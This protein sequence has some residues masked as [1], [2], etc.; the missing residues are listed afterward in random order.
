MNQKNGAKYQSSP[1]ERGS[2]GLD[3]GRPNLRRVVPARAGVIRIIG[4]NA[5]GGKRRP[6]ASGGHP[7]PCSP[8]GTSVVSS[9][10]E[11][12]SSAIFAGCTSH[13]QVVPARAGV[14][15]LVSLCPRRR[16]GR[17]RASG[18]HPFTPVAGQRRPLS[19]PR[20]RGS[21]DDAVDGRAP[22]S[23]VPARAGVIRCVSPSPAGGA[24][25]PRASGGHPAST[26][27]SHCSSPSSPRERGSSRLSRPRGCRSESSPR[28]RGSSARPQHPRL[29]HCVVPAR[30]GV[31]RGWCS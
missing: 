2:S 27:R 8:A 26:T 14:I 31:I 28:E 19:S 9:P 30:A 4:G 12:G 11:R 25:R 16:R 21:S 22:V 3:R 20:E 23:V 17:P 15:R 5:P 1:R 29:P 24:G 10:R 18:G 13:S 6:R 7:M